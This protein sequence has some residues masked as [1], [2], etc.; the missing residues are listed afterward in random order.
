MLCN[1]A[2]YTI[3]I[4]LFPYAWK[5]K[6]NNTGGRNVFVDNRGVE[7][8]KYDNGDGKKVLWESFIKTYNILAQVKSA[9]TYIDNNTNITYKIFII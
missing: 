7:M 2:N 1:M 6:R 3:W 8:G 9:I 5:I 4:S